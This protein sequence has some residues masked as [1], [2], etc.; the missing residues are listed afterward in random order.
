MKD[1]E[2]ACERIQQAQDFYCKND[3][4]SYIRVLDQAI[5]KDPYYGEPHIM[6]GFHY[7]KER[8]WEK[9]QEH[10]ARAIQLDYLLDNNEEMA[11]KVYITLGKVYQM[12]G[13]KEE[14]LVIFKSYAGLFSYSPASEKLILQIFS[15]YPEVEKWFSLFKKGYNQ[16]LA[17]N[18]DD[19]LAYFNGALQLINSYSWLHYALGRTWASLGLHEEAVSSYKKALE[20]DEHF[21]FHYALHTSYSALHREADSQKSLERALEINPFYHLVLLRKETAMR[22]F[23]IQ[24]VQATV[25][26]PAARA[27]E[28][29]GEDKTREEGEGVE[30]MAAT[31]R[32][33][34]LLSWKMDEFRRYMEQVFAELKV[35][36]R[37]ELHAL[38]DEEIKGASARIQ[39]IKDEQE[40]LEESLL[41]RIRSRM[42]EVGAEFLKN[43]ERACTDLETL[44]TDLRVSMIEAAEKL[45]QDPAPASPEAPH[46]F[47]EGAAQKLVKKKKKR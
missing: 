36:A 2:E 24:D 27:G 37:R 34:E 43:A 30:E 42:D 28:A 16:F 1:R 41:I 31:Q 11:E 12:R 18:Y 38:M 26:K 46:P 7:F 20:I 5:R 47:T 14:S 23:H 25:Q 39:I 10:L 22:R 29:S 9:A 45:E 32:M 35:R 17:K 21:I 33:E 13:R 8:Q 44:S 4:D 6:L 19:A 3:K 15:R 40:A